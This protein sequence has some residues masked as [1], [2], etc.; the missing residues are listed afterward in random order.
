M[1]RP[2]LHKIRL[3]RRSVFKR[4]G[5]VCQYCGRPTLDH[6]VPKS[7]GGRSTW[8]NLVSACHSCNHKKADRIP[9]VWLDI[10]E[11]P[12]GWRDYFRGG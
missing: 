12:G 10:L 5:Y 7:Q 1:V 2:R 8:D 9:A 6:V 11:V 4:D 3:E